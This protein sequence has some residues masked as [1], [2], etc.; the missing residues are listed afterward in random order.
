MIFGFPRNGKP[1]F[2]YTS[3]VPLK[4]HLPVLIYLHGKPLGQSVH[5]AQP[6]SVQSAGYLVPASAE[7]SAGMKLGQTYLYRRYSLGLVYPRGN[8]APVVFYRQRPVCIYRHLDL[9]TVT[10]QSLVYGIV[11]YL[12]RKMMKPP[13]V[14]RPDI[15][16][17]PL[18]HRLQPL[19]Y[20]YLLF[21]VN[22]FRFGHTFSSLPPD[23]FYAFQPLRLTSFR[24]PYLLFTLYY[25][26]LFF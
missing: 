14:S 20:L 21:S 3:E 4:M 23:S 18:P 6:H 2:G 10:R 15:H 26:S 9:V 22:I 16:S 8:T 5:Y 11:H 7:L 17:R 13:L 25:I 24:K 19:Q 1:A 12:D